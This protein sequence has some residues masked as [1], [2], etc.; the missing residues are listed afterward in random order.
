MSTLPNKNMTVADV[1]LPLGR[2]PALR[3][4]AFLKTALEEMSKSRLGIVCVTDVDG[5]LVGILT[6]GDVR[7]KLLTVQKPFS[8]FFGDDIIDHAKR[9]PSTVMPQDSLITAVTLMEE[10]QIWDLP[11]VDAEGI[12]VGLLHL[13]PVVQALLDNSRQD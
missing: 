7:R 8:A 12:L 1:A 5:R 13:H 6:D 4:T 3:E 10:K 11:V 9:G 2:F